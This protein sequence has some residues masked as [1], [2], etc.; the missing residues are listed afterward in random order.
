MLPQ[1]RVLALQQVFSESYQD[2]G[3][4]GKVSGVQMHY[5]YQK[6]HKL[7]VNNTNREINY[8]LFG[9]CSLRSGRYIFGDNLI[10][11]IIN[12]KFQNCIP[13]FL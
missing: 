13:I 5:I 8:S 1:D 11:F 10:L 12:A 4:C 2:L 6:D 9:Q 7:C 3:P